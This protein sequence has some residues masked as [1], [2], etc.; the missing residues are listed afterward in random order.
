MHSDPTYF[1]YNIVDKREKVV[2]LFCNINRL[3]CFWSNGEFIDSNFH[4]ETELFLVRI[5]L[6]KMNES[7]TKKLYI[8]NQLTLI[9]YISLFEQLICWYHT[10]FKNEKSFKCNV[11][12]EIIYNLS[13]FCAQIQIVLCIVLFISSSSYT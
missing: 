8:L 3:V 2:L 6:R 7:N 11:L 12:Y 9:S 1:I 4:Q 13:K 10:T 5:M